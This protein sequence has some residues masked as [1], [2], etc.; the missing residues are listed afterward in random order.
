M[1]KRWLII[2]GL[3][4][5]FI[6]PSSYSL[7]CRTGDIWNNTYSYGD[8]YITTGVDTNATTEC[9]TDEV[10][11]GNGSCL[12][13]SNFYDDTDTTYTAG[14]NISIT[15]EIIS[16]NVPTLETYLDLIYLTSYENRS[17]LEI[18]TLAASIDSNRSVLKL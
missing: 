14:S 1:K 16:L 13:S 17:D 2:L 10:L 15:N 7:I 4:L 3:F 12:A 11:L 9:S 6:I 8:I 18:L 5:L